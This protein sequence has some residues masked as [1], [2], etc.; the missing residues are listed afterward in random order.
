MLLED[1]P[2]SQTG[3]TWALNRQHFHKTPRVLKNMGDIRLGMFGQ[4][5][6]TRVLHAA[7]GIQVWL[8]LG[9]VARCFK[10]IPTNTS[11]QLLTSSL[12]LADY[13]SQTSRLVC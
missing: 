11:T 13:K 3:D 1:Y 6:G 5:F 4:G 2:S 8:R 7:S 9:F 12:P 10:A